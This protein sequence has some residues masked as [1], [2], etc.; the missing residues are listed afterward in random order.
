MV[1]HLDRAFQALADGTRRA[2]VER[3]VQGPTSVSDLARPFDMSLPGV[4]QHLQVLIDA[5]LVA[6]EKTGRVRTCRIEPAALRAAEGWITTQ[7]TG[8]ERSFDRLGDVLEKSGDSD[9]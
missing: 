2:I 5:G 9:D 6:T 7:R 3:L 4:L 1:N 8:W